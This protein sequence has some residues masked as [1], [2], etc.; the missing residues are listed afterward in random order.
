[1]K[2]KIKTYLITILPLA[3]GLA[4]LLILLFSRNN[5]PEVIVGMLEVNEINV[6]SKIPGRVA[7][8]LVK[9]G[10]QVKAGQ[11]LAVL[12]SKEISAKVEQ[13]KGAVKAADS[14][15]NMAKKG[16]REEEKRAVENQLAQAKSQF[17][18]AEST[19]KRVE[20]MYKENVIALQKKEEAEFSFKAAR[21][22][23]AAAQAKYDM[24]L[25]GA[26]EEEIS[27]A[28]GLSYQANS[29]LSE[30]MAYYDEREVRSPI[31]GEIFKK[32][33]NYGEIVAS[34]Y[35]VYTVVN[36][37][38]IWAV[39]NIREDLLPHFSMGKTVKAELP[40]LS[41][42]QIEFKVEY[43]AAMADFATWRATNQK[44]EYDL[45]T[46][47]IHLRPLSWHPD[48]KAGMTVRIPLEAISNQK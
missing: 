45:K 42:Q 12:D 37:K 10:E 18:L 33:T 44:G 1:M 46:F 38:D 28:E 7:E 48:M 24:V 23:Y 15:M 29:A 9:E 43:I 6:A 26:R 8:L 25:K 19:Y 40:G 5:Q 3:F 11:L 13:A 31:D 39:I 2:S 36:T 21:D 41:G 16:A 17:E 30:V 22:Q 32:V 47:E 20:K 27:G 14:R 4:A 35:P 34:G